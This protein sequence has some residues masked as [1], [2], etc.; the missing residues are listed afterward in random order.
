MTATAENGILQPGEYTAQLAIKNVTPYPIPRV[1]VTMNVLP[2]PTWGK[3]QGTVVG[4]PCTGEPEPIQAFVRISLANNPEIGASIRADAQGRYAWWLPAGNY[5]VIA[6]KDDWNPQAKMTNLD[7]GFVNTVNFTLTP[8]A[9]CSSG[10][11]QQA[12]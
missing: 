6:A 3:I 12:V 11:T 8:F 5:Q 1:D 7:A 9:G 2:P 10:G 4:Q